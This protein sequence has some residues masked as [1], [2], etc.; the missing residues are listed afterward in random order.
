LPTSRQSPR[1]QPAR[2][3]ELLQAYVERGVLR[4]AGPVADRGAGATF[5]IVWFRD[6]R[7][8]LEVDV[9]RARLRLL[10]LLPP[11]APRSGVDRQLRQW[12][13]DRQAPQLPPH[14]RVDAERYRLGLRNAGGRVSLWLDCLDGD[15]EAGLRQLLHLV[16]AMYL[17]FLTDARRHDWLVDAFDLDPDQL[18]WP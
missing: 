3:Q 14:R 5:D 12:L 18:Q 16:N 6:R 9:K 8:R 10:D 1:L 17:D 2:L 13:R 11:L 15:F 4:G 7:M